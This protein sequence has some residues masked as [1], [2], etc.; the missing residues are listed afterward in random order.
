MS[1]DQLAE[2]PGAIEGAPGAMLVIISGP[3]GV[4]KDTVLRILKGL[5]S[6][7]RRRFIVTYKSRLPRSTERDGVDYH[8]VSLDQFGALRA[9]GAL[10]E[11]AEV[12]GQWSGTPVDAVRRAL[13]EGVDPVLK[14]DVQGAAQVRRLV[15]D[16]LR[17]FV[18]PPSYETL[19]KWLIARGTDSRED[20]ERRL[21]NARVELST[22]A[23]YDHRVVNEEGD[24]VRTAL[25]IDAL[26]EQE[27]A[28][29]GE[30]RVR[31]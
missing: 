15:P 19:C 13:L 2:L 27:H 4:G 10:L 26:I 24:P 30:R 14:I 29:R 16:A 8:F 5:P 7:P 18:A 12:H 22:A 17:I 1:I 31:V 20:V 3:S 9:S 11:A 21:E 28:A 6:A 23:E 25:T